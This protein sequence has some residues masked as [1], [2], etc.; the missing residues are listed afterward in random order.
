M[1]DGLISTGAFVFG[2]VTPERLEPVRA[3]HTSVNWLPLGSK[4]EVR[5]L[6][7]CPYVP[8]D[9]ARE[10]ALYSLLPHGSLN[11][12]LYWRW[13]VIWAEGPK[14]L[15]VRHDGQRC[16]DEEWHWHWRVVRTS[17]FSDELPYAVG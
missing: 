3:K 10:R 13:D 9:G 12:L 7:L 1:T 11:C 17:G 15:F 4:G 8:N 6:G 16:Q 2:V 14:D 5:E